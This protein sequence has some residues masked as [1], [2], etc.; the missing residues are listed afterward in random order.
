[1]HKSIARGLMAGTM[2]LALVA[3]G[4]KDASEDL[5]K[6]QVVA[7]VDGKDITIHELNTELQD[8]NMPS[9]DQR[10][11]V[12]QAALQQVVNRRILADIA[13][14]RGLD[15]TPQYLL[16]QRRANDAILVQMLQR[17]IASTLRA[18]TRDEATKFMADN[19][20]RFAQR[21]VYT[22]DQIQFETPK[23]LEI[24]KAYQPLKTLDQVAVK[25]DEDHLRFRR[26]NG[27]L[28]ALT[29]PP[30]LLAQIQRLPEGEIFIIPTPRGMVANRITA[31]KVVPF[32]GD[33][34]LNYAMQQ[35]QAQKLNELATKELDEKVK[36][37]RE[38]VKYQPGYAP[39]KGAADA[40]ALPAPSGTPSPAASPDAAK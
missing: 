35:V 25:L 23:D 17:S 2:L 22:V 30:Q 13:R 34:A 12:E 10:K 26:G 38:A 1:M 21:K 40:P 14:E 33:E 19:P 5:E 3:C 20:E 11:A 32:E 9:G 28:D 7:T 39:P 27:Q 16:Q 18:P 15:K 6:G 4:K 37:A 8:V 36:T 24:L 29:V 31:T